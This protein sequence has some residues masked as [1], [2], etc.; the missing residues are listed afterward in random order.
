MLRTPAARF[1]VPS[2][3]VVGTEEK[4]KERRR[5]IRV[6]K[7][8]VEQAEA[9]RI[10]QPARQK[11]AHQ[12][13][14]GFSAQAAADRERRA[15]P[16]ARP[17]PLQ[18]PRPPLPGPLTVPNPPPT[19]T[20]PEG[21]SAEDI[22]QMYASFATEVAAYAAVTTAMFADQ[23]SRRLQAVAEQHAA[24][25]DALATEGLVTQP[26][27]ALLRRDA[28]RVQ[29]TLR[30]APTYE[31]RYQDDGDEDEEED[32][33]EEADDEEADDAISEDNEDPDEQSSMSGS[34]HSSGSSSRSETR[35]QRKASKLR[36]I[37]L[38]GICAHSFAD[39][40][41]TYNPYQ[42]HNLL[43]G[44]SIAALARTTLVKL[45]EPGV[46]LYCPP[47]GAAGLRLSPAFNGAT[48]KEQLLTTDVPSEETRLS[49]DGAY[50][51]P[52]L[53]LGQDVRLDSA[54]AQTA[55]FSKLM[56][57]VSTVH[58][59]DGEVRA[60]HCGQIA[61]LDRAIRGWVRPHQEPGDVSRASCAY[62]VWN[63][64]LIKHFTM[65]CVNTLGAHLF[66]S[67]KHI[68]VEESFPLL[69][70]TWTRF[71]LPLILSTSGTVPLHCTAGA[72]RDCSILLGNAC[73][74]CGQPG[75]Q[76]H[77]CFKCRPESKAA[78]RSGT[79]YPAPFNAAYKLL[80]DKDAKSCPSKAA[81]AKGDGAKHLP[82]GFVVADSRASVAPT[83]SATSEAAFWLSAVT[84]QQAKFE[85]SVS[86]AY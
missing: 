7:A 59:L 25:Q 52:T 37:R 77:S 3:P 27:R 51:A 55:F 72:L 46:S 81:Y 43:P 34:A 74:E 16:E 38:Q 28:P 11:R 12:P 13:T 31:T 15:A 84:R 39:A 76:T 86:S 20:P 33:E 50:V 73:E 9:A 19:P 85:V 68:T 69:Q 70:S 47:S 66:R 14:A 75:Q 41:N 53:F 83:P 61:E 63:A 17:A 78:E 18:L 44:L 6:T 36:A 54:R 67:G 82:A 8:L 29:G 45:S 58:G 48:E 21:A 4:E 64:G 79:V 80:R 26:G 23:E 42:A 1:S 30:S 35:E 5:A 49:P 62:W 60:W 10:M 24:Q 65:G 2:S 71:Y 57:H 40:A 22:A 32:A 56:G